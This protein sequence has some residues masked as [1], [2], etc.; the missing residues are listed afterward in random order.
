M[1]LVTIIN[2]IANYNQI[3]LNYHTDHSLKQ[4]ISI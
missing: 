4:G 3:N 1:W 2:T